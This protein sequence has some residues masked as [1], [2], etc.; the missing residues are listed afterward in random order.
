[1][2]ELN[3]NDYAKYFQD[4]VGNLA[5]RRQM[6]KDKPEL[7]NA[8]AVYEKDEKAYAKDGLSP[9]EKLVL[10][11]ISGILAHHIKEHGGGYY[12]PEAKN[13]LLAATFIENIKPQVRDQVEPTAEEIAVRKQMIK[14]TP[15]LA[16]PLN[17]YESIESLLSTPSATDHKSGLNKDDVEVLKHSVINISGFIRSNEYGASTEKSKHVAVEAVLER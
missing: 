17:R 3:N 13:A 11:S 2:S 6:V 10:E 16:T 12:G 9:S 4:N 7:E 14:D 8:A 1:M 5:S 15:A